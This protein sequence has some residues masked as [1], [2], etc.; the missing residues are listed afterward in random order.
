MK[1]KVNL[2][3]QNINKSFGTDILKQVIESRVKLAECVSKFS[4]TQEEFEYNL[5]WALDAIGYPVSN[6][7]DNVPNPAKSKP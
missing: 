1:N 2:V 3:N 6:N 7:Y 5:I 4:N